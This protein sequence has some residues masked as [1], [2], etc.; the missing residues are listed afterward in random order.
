LPVKIPLKIFA[1]IG[2]YAE[3]WKNKA[4]NDRFL[5]DAGFQISLLKE[6]INI[7]VPLIYSSVYRDYLQ[8]TILKKE[9]FFKKISF[10]IDISNF[11]LRKIDR[12]LVF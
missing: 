8:S 4:E 9:R 2:T 5:Y 11:S 6:T 3:A 10:S 1:D 12:N 7:Y